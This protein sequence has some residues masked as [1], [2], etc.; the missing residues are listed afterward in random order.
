MDLVD[1]SV[2]NTHTYIFALVDNFSVFLWTRKLLNRTAQTIIH[3]L[4]KL[5]KP[6]ILTEV[7]ELIQDYYKVIMEANFQML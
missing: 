7:M 3:N 2:G 6:I 5:L 1:M 4:N